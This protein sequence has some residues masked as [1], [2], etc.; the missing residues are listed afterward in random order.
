MKDFKGLNGVKYEGMEEHNGE[1]TVK[2]SLES[3]G[4]DFRVEDDGI[5]VAYAKRY[6][7]AL[8]LRF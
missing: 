2:F 3:G 7:H 1:M 6:A 5:K 4:Y 8:H